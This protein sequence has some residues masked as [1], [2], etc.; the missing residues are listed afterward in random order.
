[1]SPLCEAQ[2]PS[3]LRHSDLSTLGSAAAGDLRQLPG[4][5]PLLLLP[6]REGPR[7]PGVGACLS[8][9]PQAFPLRHILPI[10]KVTILLPT[11]PGCRPNPEGSREGCP[12]STAHTVPTSCCEAVRKRLDLSEPLFAPL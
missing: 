3:D 7:G 5:F 6:T 10:S 1:M 4:A 9:R 2:L 8:R 12:A 11:V